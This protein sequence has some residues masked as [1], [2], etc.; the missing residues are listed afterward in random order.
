MPEEKYDDLIGVKC[1]KPMRAA[2]KRIAGARGLD[3]T[4]LL[5]AAGLAIV[6]FAALYG[7]APAVELAMNL[8]RD[9]TPEELQ[10][11]AEGATPYSSHSAELEAVQTAKKSFQAPPVQ[12]PPS[13][14]GL[15]PSAAEKHGKKSRRKFGPK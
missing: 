5:R 2:L 7:D 9:F 15:P 10:R 8:G 3:D 12:A 1:H 14:Q 4:D 11:V 6:D 13:P